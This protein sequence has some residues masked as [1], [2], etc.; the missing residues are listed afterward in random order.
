MRFLPQSLTLR[1]CLG[2]LSWTFSYFFLLS[3]FDGGPLSIF[4]VIHNF[5]FLQVFWFDSSSS[6]IVSPFPF[7]IKSMA[8]FFHPKFHSYFLAVY[9][10][11]KG[12]SYFSMFGK[13]ISREMYRKLRIYQVTGK[14]KQLHV[15]IIHI[16]KAVYLFSW[17]GK[18]VTSVAFPKYINE[19]HHCYN[20]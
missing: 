14:D 1:S 5:L 20:N 13:Y 9:S 18:F 10:L 7:F 15:Y 4:L 12:F 19:W 2:L 3:L 6:T 11:Y 8:Y 17:L 16:H